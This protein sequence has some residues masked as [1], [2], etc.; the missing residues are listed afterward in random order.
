[1]AKFLFFQKLHS[2]VTYF[3]PLVCTMLTWRE[4]AF[5]IFA[6]AA[7]GNAETTAEFKFRTCVTCHCIVD[8]FINEILGGATLAPVLFVGRG[9]RRIIRSTDRKVQPLSSQQQKP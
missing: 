3:S 9:D 8:S 5:Q 4:R 2:V 7:Q 6:C 1:M